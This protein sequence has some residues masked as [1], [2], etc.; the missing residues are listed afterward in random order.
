M[1]SI[2]QVG[3]SWRASV[4]L[5]GHKPQHKTFEKKGDAK[6]WADDVEYALRHSSPTVGASIT[7]FDCIAHYRKLRGLAKRP[8]TKKSNTFFMLRHLEDEFGKRKVL[9]LKTADYSAWV[10]KRLKFGGGR[11]AIGQELSLLR[12]VYKRAAA[13]F[14]MEI[15]DHLGSAIL[16][17]STIGAVFMTSAERNRYITEEEFLAIYNEIKNP[18]MRD[19]VE[20]CYKLG[21]RQGEALKLIWSDFNKD[22]V[23]L[24]LRDRKHPRK[25]VTEEISLLFSTYLILERQEKPDRKPTDKIFQGISGERLSDEFL[26]ATRKLEI[27]DCRFHDLRHTAITNLFKKGLPIQEVSLLSG[28]KDWKMLKRYTHLDPASLH[29]HPNLQTE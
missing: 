7:V 25:P 28:H 29:T 23:M 16:N 18:I 12:T 6:A 27:E 3:D 26:R 15:P 14:T 5:A 11:V 21:I 10:E 19:V 20:L 4:R 17:L 24:K 8:I 22:T 13:E 1:A 2:I 9:E